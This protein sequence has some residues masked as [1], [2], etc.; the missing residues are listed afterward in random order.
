MGRGGKVK[1]EKVL[2]DLLN[3]NELHEYVETLL[4]EQTEEIINLIRTEM[5][6]FAV[7]EDL[8]SKFENEREINNELTLEINE[9]KKENELYK[10]MIEDNTSE[11]KT[12]KLKVEDAETEKLQLNAEKEKIENN[13]N[14]IKQQIL[15]EK[16]EKEIALKKANEYEKNFKIAENIYALY[17]KIPENI[18]QRV[19]NIFKGGN[20]YS[21]IVAVSD[22]NNI[23]GLWGFVKRRIIE[24]DAEGI[25]ELIDLFSNSFE[26]FSLINA[27]TRYVLLKPTVGEHFDSDKHSIKGIKTDGQIEKVLLNGIYDVEMK[28]TIFKAVVEVGEIGERNGYNINK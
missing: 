2:R 26:L 12:L 7:S 16:E 14:N 4:K 5:N 24:E 18:K 15:C 28:R 22:W 17:Q 1:E 27:N 11:N 20:R 10:K 9:L 23:E 21:F 8:E 6:T 25:S 3:S 19:S 13:L